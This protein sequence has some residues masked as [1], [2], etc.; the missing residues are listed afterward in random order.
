MLLKTVPSSGTCTATRPLCVALPV[1]KSLKIGY[2]ALFQGVLIYRYVFLPTATKY[3]KSSSVR[4][5][6]ALIFGDE[7]GARRSGEPAARIARRPR[8][9]TI[10]R[11]LSTGTGGP[12]LENRGHL[13]IVPGAADSCAGL[14]DELNVISVRCRGRAYVSWYHSTYPGQSGPRTVQESVRTEQTQGQS[15]P[16]VL[17][18]TRVSNHTELY[19][20]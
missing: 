19:L 8:R 20:N 16:P 6:A 12:P 17:H 2:V 14:P 9:R 1:I 11:Q 13:A 5:H 18:T 7:L 3:H 10:E 15:R 4:R